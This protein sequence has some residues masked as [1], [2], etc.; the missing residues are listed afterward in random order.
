[1]TTSGLKEYFKGYY[2]LYSS[3]TQVERQTVDK[4][5]ALLHN[6]AMNLFELAN[7]L[8]KPGGDAWHHISDLLA[9]LQF[10]RKVHMS[11]ESIGVAF[12]RYTNVQN[13]MGAAT[14]YFRAML[15]T[16]YFDNY[17]QPLPLILLAVNAREM[18]AK[19]SNGCNYRGSLLTA[20]VK[21]QDG[22]FFHRKDRDIEDYPLCL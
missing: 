11:V 8:M 22:T 7:M 15:M 17:Y 6:L 1:M 9:I 12:A 16:M 13:T 4:K 19:A 2:Y 21:I 14:F 5:T 10:M 18:N 20:C 3:M